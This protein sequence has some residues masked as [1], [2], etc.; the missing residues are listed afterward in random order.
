MCKKWNIY[1]VDLYGNGQ[2]NTIID[3][4]KKYTKN[5]DGTHPTTEGYLKYYIPQILNAIVNN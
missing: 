5:E 4:Y 2:L 3:G 1:I